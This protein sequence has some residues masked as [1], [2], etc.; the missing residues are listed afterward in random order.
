[1]N[2]RTG[3]KNRFPLSAAQ[4]GVWVA[5]NIDIKNPAYNCGGYLEINGYVDREEFEKAV[6]ICVHETEALQLSFIED[7]SGLYQLLKKPTDVLLDYIDASNESEPVKYSDAWMKD[8][9]AKPVSLSSDFLFHHAL[10][11]VNETSFLFYFRYHHIVMDGYSQMLYWSR[12]AEI[13]TG[14]VSGEKYSKPVFSSIAELLDEESAYK[15]SSHYVKDR[16]YWLN[17]LS[18]NLEPSRLSG[19]PSLTSSKLLRRFT[20]LDAETTV[21]LV[22][23]SRKLQTRWSVLVL[24]ATAVYISRLSSM[25]EVILTLPVSSRMTQATRETP[26]MLANE[27]P[28]NIFVTPGISLKDLARQVS[29]KISYTL[30]HQRYRGEDLTSE[31]RNINLSNDISGPVVNI[32]P[33]DHE[34]NFSGI[35]SIPHH[36]SSGSVTDLLIGFYGKSD[37]TNLQV[38]FDANPDLYTASDLAK[39]QNRFISYLKSL[40]LSKPENSVFKTDILLDEERNKIL[41]EF[42]NTSRSYD[43]SKCLHEMFTE[44]A[45]KT[46]YV[47]AISVLGSDMSYR[48]LDEQSNK[49]AHYLVNQGVQPGQRVAVCDV[50]SLELVIELIAVLKVGAAYVPIDHELPQQRLEYQINDADIRVVLTSSEISKRFVKTKLNIVPVDLLLP[51][52]MTSIEKLSTVISSDSAAYV[53]Y[54]SGSTG[55]PKGVVVPH[56]G[57][58]NRLLWMQ[59][60]YGLKD[61]DCVLQKTPFTFDVSVWEFFWPLITG[62][63]LFL[64]GPEL[65]RDPR[66][67]ARI[68][69]EQSISTIHFVPPML[70]MFLT[71]PDVDSLKSLKN[72]FCSGETLN[73]ESVKLFYDIYDN[74]V[75]DVELHNLYGPTEASIDVTSWKCSPGDAKNS[76]PI[77]FPVANTSIYILDTNGDPVPIGT[78][79]ELYIGGTQVALG[80][81]NR[82]DLTQQSFLENPFN[83]GVMYR[84]GDLARFRDD[85]AIEYIGRLDHQIKIRGFRIEL[86]EIES[87]LRLHS[88]IIQ[89]VVTTFKR[90]SNDR[91][92]VAYIVLGDSKEAAISKQEIL[93]Y[94]SEI[95]PEYMIPSYIIFLDEIPL[96]AN[97]KTNRRA[98]PEPSP[99]QTKVKLKPKSF[100]EK[101][102]YDIWCDVLGAEDFSINDSFFSLGGD[103]MLSIRIRTAIEKQGFTFEI[104]DIFSS[105]TIQQLALQLRP[106]DSEHKNSNGFSA[107]ELLG[108]SDKE[109]LPKGLDDAYPLSSMQAGMLVQA[110]LHSDTAVYRVVTSLHVAVQFNEKILKQSLSETFQRHPALRSSYDVSSYSEPIQLIHNKVETEVTISNEML[111]IESSEQNKFITD[112]MNQAKFHQFDIGKAPLINFVVHI[113]DMGSFQL[114]VIEHHVVLDG[115]SDVVMLDEIISRYRAYMSGEQLWLPEIPSSYRD[116]VG[117]ERKALNNQVSKDYWLNKLQGIEPAPLPRSTITTNIDQMINKSFDVP[118]SASVVKKLRQIARVQKL[119]LKSLL[120]VAHIAVLRL[121]CSVEEVVTGIVSNGRLEQEGG[122]EVIGVFLNTLPIK[123]NTSN[124]SLIDVANEVFQNESEMSPHRRYP[125]IQMQKNFDGDLQLDSY[126]NFMDFHQ[127]WHQDEK[128]EGLIKE[129]IGLAETNF[130]LAVNFLIDPVENKLKLWLDC[131]VTILDEGF[132]QRLTGYYQKALVIMSETPQCNFEVMELIS[133]SEKEKLNSWDKT[134]VEFDRNMTVHQLIESQVHLSASSIAVSHRWQQFTYGEL[135][136]RSNQLAHYL[137][138]NNVSKNSLVGVS[139]H[140]GLDLVVSLLAVLKVG[141]AYVP[142]DPAFPKTRLDFIASDSEIN[143]L[144]TSQTGP[145]ELLVP[146]IILLDTNAE[147]ISECPDTTVISNTSG[148]DLAYVIYTSGS[149]GLPKGTPIKHRNV[150]NFFTGMNQNIS[151]GED[152]VVLALTS[153]SFDISVLELLWPLTRGAKVVVAGERLI[154]NLVQDTGQSIEALDFSLFFFGAATG[155][156]ERHNGYQLVMDA[157][158]FGD[159]HGFTAVWTPERHFHEFGGLYPNPSVLSAAIAST[160]QRID[161][162]CGSVVSPLHN[163][164]RIAEEWSLVDNLS[165]G[166]VGLAFASGWNANDFVLSP[167]SYSQRKEV[168]TKQLDEFRSLWRGET[169]QRINGNGDQVDVRIY[170]SPVQDEPPVWFTAAGAVGT[171]EMAGNAGVNILTHMLGQDLDELAE[172]IKVYQNARKAHGHTGKGCVT[173]MVHTF[174]LDDAEQAKQTARGPFR[175]YLRTSAGLLGMLSASMGMDLPDSMTEEDLESILDMAVERYF[176]RSGLFGSPETALSMI[177]NLAMAGIDEVACLIDFGIDT[178]DVVQSLSSLNKLKELHKHEVADFDHSLVELCRRHK[179]TLI[180]S[181]PSFMSAVVAEPSALKVLKDLRAVLVGGEAFPAGVAQRLLSNLPESQVY[182]MYGPTETT[183]WS[184]V[185]KLDPLHDMNSSIIPIGKP[186]ANTHL[187][188]LNSLFKPVPISVEGELWIGGDGVAKEY[189]NRPETTAERFIE[190]PDG[191]GKFMYRTGDRVRWRSD[192]VLEFLGRIDRQVKILGHRIEPDEIESVLSRHEGVDSVAVI[193]VAKENGPTELIA[194][195]SSGNKSIDADEEIAYIKH[196]GNAWEDAYTNPETGVVAGD[197]KSDFAGWLSSYTNEPISIEEMREWLQ[198]TVNKISALKS[199]SVVDVGVGVGLILREIAPHVQHYLGIDISK[200]AL[201]N[202]K[203]SLGEE[204]HHKDHLTLVHGDASYLKNIESRNSAT[205]VMNSVIQ[206]F[207]GTDYLKEVIGESI[208]VAGKQGKVFIGDVRSLELLEAFQATVQ[209]HRVPPLTTVKEILSIIN[210]QVIAERELCLSTGFFRNIA[211][212]FET[213]SEVR[214]ELKRGHALNELTCFRYDVTLFADSEKQ[215]IDSSHDI[216]WD[217]LSKDISYSQFIFDKFI[218]ADGKSF[219]ISSIPNARLTRPLALLRLLRSVNENTTAWELERLLW[220]ECSSNA[221]NPEVV[222]E[223][224]DKMGWKVNLLIPENGRLDE[225]DAVFEVMEFLSSAKVSESLTITKNKEIME[226]E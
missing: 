23:Q 213:I 99:D 58:V 163:S 191:S 138:Q 63:R 149:T 173:V 179:V 12:L 66:A 38:Y 164:I 21:A 187:L 39:H 159:E 57:I 118:I 190:L 4:E 183:I 156:A 220:E 26:F 28:I 215:K 40:C 1:M 104:R 200:A 5:Q 192:G 86:D 131:D 90:S 174:L 136:A 117:V 85:G 194:Y 140:R 169:V 25:E 98:L 103:S 71:E 82:D 3:N 182:N 34:I 56:K 209:L 51:K 130:P 204:S 207:P 110:E 121:V 29:E 119:P 52:L 128:N 27:L 53:I 133:V 24:A 143:C 155:D 223:I 45:L 111:N 108:R 180:Q 124:K 73:S 14:L 126:V 199:T 76:V 150:V 178:N 160:T 197:S 153:V 154:N 123:V 205:V 221:I 166:R 125:F 61:D 94:L 22:E 219:M 193:A 132:C 151:C 177:Q 81:L 196:W 13:Y 89:S 31:L 216:S 148:D 2:I 35:E 75:G 43:L 167:D 218:E 36:L 129:A 41:L 83:E 212:D 92:L 74:H 112:W 147:E 8:D 60:T 9:L 158:R 222:A 107:F 176:E 95:L 211:K 168:M 62:S 46:P 115:W 55:Q 157:A 135:N 113:R 67:I 162:R 142:L 185:H 69:K 206:Y 70:D 208:R 145:T 20:C 11:K 84:T 15:N 100:E 33:I 10:F 120:T 144:I 122:D 91:R 97:G 49:L 54:T 114:S 47:T 202:A 214:L 101:L 181:T 203:A 17:C 80:Y 88:S 18:D 172:K 30:K 225:F 96:M 170:P 78:P 59:E 37:G 171:F 42:N 50:R 68:I 79:G 146:N 19:Q 226:C 139:L 165:Q 7:D 141:A 93:D 189:L 77:G 224:A 72:V 109:K 44:Q 134:N 137:L 87:V 217:S 6:N 210:R 116:F 175:E 106:F 32:I 16:N 64:A 198:H 105:P 127:Q 184:T 188:V 48:D 195:I 201:Q 152:D 186:I 65:H 161:L 102:L